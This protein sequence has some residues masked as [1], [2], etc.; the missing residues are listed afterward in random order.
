M[1]V[2]VEGPLESFEGNGGLCISVLI[3]LSERGIKE[4]RE[5]CRQREG[6]Q[7]RLFSFGI[8]ILG[9]TGPGVSQSG[10]SEGGGWAG[11][12]RRAD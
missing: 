6:E 11:G 3:F 1:C 7:E 12:P 2:M 10:G 9:H 5:K 8:W 4:E